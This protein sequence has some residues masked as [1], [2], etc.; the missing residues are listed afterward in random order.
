MSEKK[1][2]TITF[3]LVKG[4][5]IKCRVKLTDSDILEVGGAL[6]GAMRGNYVGVELAGKLTLMPLYNV[7]SIEIDPSPRRVMD[8]VVQGAEPVS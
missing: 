2:F 7:Q 1:T 5:P 8:H 6:G 3:N 4:E